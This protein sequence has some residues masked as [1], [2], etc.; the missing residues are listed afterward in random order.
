MTSAHQPP[1]LVR[2]GIRWA[3]VVLGVLVGAVVI[4][5]SR[6]IE[7]GNGERAIDALAV[8]CGVVAGAALVFWR[9]FAV[10]MVAVV[11]LVTFV[12]HVRNYPGG[13]ALIPGP[14]S[15]LLLGYRERRSVAL[16]GASLMAVVT[17]VGAWIGD[18]ELRYTSLVGIGWSFAAAFAGML[19]AARGERVAAERERQE[20][21]QHQAVV[22]ERLR[23]ARDLHDSVAHAMATINVQS[24]TAAHLLHRGGLEGSEVD[25][26]RAALDAIRV[27]SRDALDELGAI[28]GALREEGGAAPLAPL[29]GLERIDDLVV[30]AR[31]DGLGVEY[32]VEG[33]PNVVVPSIG[34]AAY[35]V[36]QEALSNVRVH[37]GPGATATIR[38]LVAGPGELRVDMIDD[39]GD[40]G[41]DVCATEPSTTGLGLIG[42]GERVEATGGKLAVGPVSSGTGY[43]VTAEWGS[44]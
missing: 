13:P 15:L 1:S 7:P 38:V 39:G 10:P 37:A 18:G 29:A 23:I 31:A 35:R 17:V 14:L 22:E 4:V 40:A 36:V 25:T 16:W 44:G 6:H 28:L 19:G 24:G 3:D 27:A 34:A 2:L 20:L 32:T 43:R 42:M 33:D 30:R 9:R 41:S 26:A 11:A 21:Q 8:A 12:Y 5:G